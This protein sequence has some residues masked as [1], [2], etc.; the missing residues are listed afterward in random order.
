MVTDLQVRTLM[1]FLKQDKTL[2]QAALKS[3]MDEKTARKYRNIGRLPSQMK[4][5]H[6][7]RTRDNPFD[8]V[9][10]EIKSSLESNA[11]FQAKTL[12]DDLQRRYPGRFSD[13]Q[14]RT[15]QRRIKLW[16][17]IDGPGRE[18]YFPQVHT[19]GKL[20]QSDF[21]NMNKLGITLGGQ[22]FDHLVYHF[23]L[24]YSNWETGSICFSESFESLSEGLQNALWRLGGVPQSHQTDRLSSAVNNLGSE[25]KFTA[26]Y[27][28]LINHYGMAGSKIQ[29][30]KANENGD[31]EQSHNRFK[32]AVDQALMLRGSRDFLSCA[33][34][35]K[36]LNGIF[37][38]LNAGRLHRFSE[39]LKVLRSLPAMRI[40]DFTTLNIRVGP[41]STIRA[42]KKVYSVHSRLIREKV[43]VRLYADRVEVWYAQRMVEAMPRLMGER[44]SN[45]QY[46][47]II[48]WL[49]RKPGAFS[50]YRYRDD[51]FPTSRFR[52]AYDCLRLHSPASAVREYLAILHL[53]AMESETCVDDA[54]RKL[55]N[56]ESA[57]NIE[58]VKSILKSGEPVTLATDVF[59]D[60]VNLAMYDQLLEGVTA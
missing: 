46:R 15:L 25:K 49:I 39:E 19:P 60:E 57:I 5:N 47:H 54:I 58:N 33:E 23:V 17:A 27:S 34:Y 18:V 6:T 45:I 8:D 43:T 40:D 1:K 16:R 44:K 20:C 14:L 41:S 56:D 32:V 3:G 52:M 55:I 24:T 12:F 22:S 28:G 35:E 29:A 53:A 48:G 36:F 31:V 59:I 51:L 7:W 26:R 13:G 37:K 30:G 38:Q 21:T 11:G 50:N 4:V 2:K 10:D 9:W 42:G